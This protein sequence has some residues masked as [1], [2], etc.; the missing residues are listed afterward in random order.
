MPRAP[1]I[2]TTKCKHGNLKWQS[3]LKERVKWFHNLKEELEAMCAKRTEIYET[4]IR[5]QNQGLLLMPAQNWPVQFVQRTNKT[6]T[7]KPLWPTLGVSRKT[8]PNVE[9]SPFISLQMP[10]T[11]LFLGGTVSQVH[12]K[13]S[14]EALIRDELDPG[15]VPSQPDICPDS[16]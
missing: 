5:N 15:L 11:T 2:S 8:D 6:T 10:P 14:A 16:V 9:A 12:L 1:K 13:H 4:K 3:K 7:P